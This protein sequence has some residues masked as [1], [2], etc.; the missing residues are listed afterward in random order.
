M[1]FCLSRMGLLAVLPMLTPG[2]TVG[3][4]VMTPTGLFTASGGATVG[5]GAA[6]ASA[7]GFAATSW[8]L[9]MPLSMGTRKTGGV[10][11]MVA[12]MGTVS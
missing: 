8:T 10:V 12:T 1:G 4:L 3:I 2:R 7:A 9:A 11:V 5:G 6:A